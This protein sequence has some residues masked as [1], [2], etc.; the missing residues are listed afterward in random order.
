VLSCLF[1]RLFLDALKQAGRLDF[2][3]DLAPLADQ[4]AFD[5]TVAR[6][7]GCKWVVAE[8]WI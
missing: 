8:R 1:R 6:L 4:R 3:G 7:R 2:L 5:A